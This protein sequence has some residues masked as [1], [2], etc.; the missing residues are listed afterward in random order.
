[1]GKLRYKGYVGNVEYSEEEN[2]FVGHVE[3]LRKAIIVYEGNSAET[4]R[5]DFED[6]VD[7]YLDSC[8]EKGEEPEKPYSG[9]LVL[10]ISSALHGTAAEKAEAMGISLNDFISRALQ[11]AVS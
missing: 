4:L 11:A 10:R 2:Y 9:R 3:G 5:K 1:M 7:H 8:Q 6:A